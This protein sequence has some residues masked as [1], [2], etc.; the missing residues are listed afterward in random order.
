MPERIVKRRP[1]SDE[2]KDRVSKSITTSRVCRE[3][4]TRFLLTKIDMGSTCSSKLVQS[5]ASLVIKLKLCWVSNNKVYVWGKPECLGEF[6]EKKRA[7]AVVRYHLS[8]VHFV[9]RSMNLVII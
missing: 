3:R 2:C 4:W 8:G 7:S 9:L 5:H 1:S 6:G